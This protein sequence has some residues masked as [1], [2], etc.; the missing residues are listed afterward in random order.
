M[1][2]DEVSDCFKNALNEEKKGKK[3][4]GLLI[5]EPDDKK[6]KE[7]L[8]DG[9]KVKLTLRLRGREMSHMDVANNTIQKFLEHLPGIAIKKSVDDNSNNNITIILG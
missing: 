8:D 1:E 6:A 7:F 2:S 3:H 9:D 5:T 4:K